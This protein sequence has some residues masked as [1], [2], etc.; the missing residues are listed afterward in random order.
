MPFDVRSWWWIGID[1]RV[2]IL[3]LI[4]EIGIVGVWK[5]RVCDLPFNSFVIN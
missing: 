4:E 2:W 1:V 3:D 5:F